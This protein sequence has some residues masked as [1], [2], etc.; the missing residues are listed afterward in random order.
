MSKITRKSHAV[1][2]CM[3]LS[4]KSSLQAFKALQL[5]MIYDMITRK[6]YACKAA[7][8][9]RAQ[10]PTFCDHI[11]NNEGRKNSTSCPATMG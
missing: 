3:I 7:T 5:P 6:N 11:E 2:L 10:N 1:R 4:Q 9:L 8:K